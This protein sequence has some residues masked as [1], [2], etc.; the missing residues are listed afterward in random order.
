MII[1]SFGP[2][3]GTFLTPLEYLPMLAKSVKM[4][5]VPRFDQKLYFEVQNYPILKIK[6]YSLE[7]FFDFL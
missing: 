5:A 6:V 1:F 4:F 7:H 3:K 2:S